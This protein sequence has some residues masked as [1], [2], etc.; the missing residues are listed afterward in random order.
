MAEA[1]KAKGY[2][3]ALVSRSISEE[4]STNTELHIK[5]DLSDTNVVPKIFEKVKEKFGSPPSM[6]VY[7][8]TSILSASRSLTSH[9]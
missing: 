6:V 8:G 4:T 5:A 1:F 2:N 3:L 7:N 9:D